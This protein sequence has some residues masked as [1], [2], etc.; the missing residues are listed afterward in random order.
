MSRCT[1][2]AEESLVTGEARATPRLDFGAIPVGCTHGRSS[3][4]LFRC[5]RLGLCRWQG[6]LKVA[7]KATEVESEMTLF[8]AA[9]PVLL[10]LY[11]LP[12][13]GVYPSTFFDEIADLSGVYFHG[14]VAP[15]KDTVRDMFFG[16]EFA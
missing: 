8:G 7:P 2:E 11:F 12:R 14:V 15:V 5:G 6:L 4:L 10:E 9:T 13:K 16:H 1:I 3:F